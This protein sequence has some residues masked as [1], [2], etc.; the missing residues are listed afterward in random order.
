M[1]CR[2]WYNL[3]QEKSLRQRRK[4]YLKA[5][6]HSYNLS[7]VSGK[8]RTCFVQCVRTLCAGVECCVRVVPQ[9]LVCVCVLTWLIHY[10]I[11][12]LHRKI[13][14]GILSRL[15]IVTLTVGT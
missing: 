12:V 4:H 11:C 2:S 5:R 1:V 8:G 3:A 9:H 7:R 10:P 6:Q 15:P 14:E 13:L